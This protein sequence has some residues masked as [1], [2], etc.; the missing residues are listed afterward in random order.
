MDMIDLVTGF[1]LF[2]LLVNMLATFASALIG[3]YWLTISN[4]AFGAAMLMML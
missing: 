2:V 3:N 1:I 4:L